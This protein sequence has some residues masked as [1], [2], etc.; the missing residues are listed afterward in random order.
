M[1]GYLKLS[2]MTLHDATGIRVRQDVLFRNLDGEAVLLELGA[3]RYF[4]LDEVGTRAW[5]L[6]RQHGRLGPVCD[7]LRQEYDVPQEDLRRDLQAFVHDLV[8]NRLVE[9]HEP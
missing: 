2:S 3:S 1:K 5:E 7:Q 9:V 4:G 8:S 6:L